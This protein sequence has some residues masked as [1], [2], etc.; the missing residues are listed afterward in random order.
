M[1][2]RA[3]NYLDLR[4]QG[5]LEEKPGR[6]PDMSEIAAMGMRHVMQQMLHDAETF[7]PRRE[8][9]MALRNNQ[10]RVLKDVCN[11]SK[12]LNI[13]GKP[14]TQLELRRVAPRYE[15]LADEALREIER[16]LLGH[17]SSDAL[18]RQ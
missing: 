8:A 18:S 9:A 12:E 17:A 5:V 4:T 11:P 14:L 1:W 15:A 6:T 10:A 7:A 16:R 3:I 2:V 13:D